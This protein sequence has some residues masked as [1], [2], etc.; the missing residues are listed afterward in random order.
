M[1]RAYVPAYSQATPALPPLKTSSLGRSLCMT[2]PHLSTSLL[3]AATN[4]PMCPHLPQSNPA[5][6]GQQ[7]LPHL[8]RRNSELMFTFPDEGEHGRSLGAAGGRW[9]RG[10]VPPIYLVGV[11][12]VVTLLAPLTFWEDVHPVS[13]LELLQNEIHS[14]LVDTISCQGKASPHQSPFP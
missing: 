3:P 14:L 5:R 13:I 11:G 7:P 4:T 10:L 2:I 6:E 9:R 1:S 12:W 8:K